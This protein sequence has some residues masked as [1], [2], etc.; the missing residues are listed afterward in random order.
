MANTDKNESKE[1]SKGT[2]FNIQKFSLNDGPGIRTVVFFKGCPLHCKWCSNPESQLPVPEI[3]WDSRKCH[4]CGSCVKV[5][6]E[7]CIGIDENRV[8]VNKTLCTACGKCSDECPV[9]ALNLEGELYSSD[10]ILSVCLQD[11]AFYEES[12]GGVTLSGGEL[13]MQHEFALELLSKLKDNNIS[14]CIETTGLADKKIFAEII[15]KTDVILF[16]MKHYDSAAHENA[17]GVGNKLILS[18]LKLAVNMGKSKNLL[19]RIPIIPGFNAELSDAQGFAALINEIGAKKVQL[20]PFHQFGE[21]KYD[22]IGKKYELKDMSPLHREDLA[23]YKA[24]LI[25]N[26]IDCII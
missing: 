13:L 9:G 14:T 26:G 1:C 24:V 25:N 3:A 20:L 11:S 12:G 19:V 18:N 5:C 2:I 15:E 6:S 7:K 17:T 8:S 10:E 16:D 23:E 22:L 4:H 21:N